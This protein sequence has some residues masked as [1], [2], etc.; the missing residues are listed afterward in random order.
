AGRITKSYLSLGQ[1]VQA[2]TPLFEITSSEFIEVQKEFFQAQSER[3]LALKDMKRKEDLFQNG[4]ASE[5][6]LEEAV[7]LLKIADK[8]YENAYAALQIYHVN[9]EDMRLGQPL[10]IRAPLTGN[11]IENNVV[12]GLYLKDDAEPV[13][14]V[15]NVAQVW[16]A[17]QVK[18]KDLRFIHNNSELEIHLPAYPGKKLTGKV[19]H[20]DEA[21][22]E[23]TRSVRVLSVCDN[24]DELLKLGMY[25]TVHFNDVPSPYL[26]IP[27]KA[28]LQDEKM[29]YVFVQTDTNTY[30]KTPVEVEV[31]R[32]GKAFISAGITKGLQIISE[33]G[34]Y[35]K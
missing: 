33:G 16:I 1:S 9:P 2:N 22:D 35:L 26:V 10:V 23:E 6:E 13:A 27:E 28:L 34:Y 8:E 15:A 25:V 7:N 24:P 20:I 21:I 12:T 29:T 4:V 17:A 11:V 31:T 5:K 14:V 18:E 19:F 30:Q 3:E 32:D